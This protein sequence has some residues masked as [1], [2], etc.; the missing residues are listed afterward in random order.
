[1]YTDFIEHDEKF[2]WTRKTLI[3]AEELKQKVSDHL[4][5]GKSLFYGDQLILAPRFY[6]SLPTEKQEE[7]KSEL[8]IIDSSKHININL[9]F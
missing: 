5:H 4:L 8:N 7:L 3:T 1:M 2:E 6:E 9:F